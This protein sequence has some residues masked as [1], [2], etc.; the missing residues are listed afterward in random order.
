MT[1][2][3]NTWCTP[4]TSVNLQ[5][6]CATRKRGTDFFFVDPIRHAVESRRAAVPRDP[7]RVVAFFRRRGTLEHVEVVRMDVGDVVVLWRE[8]GERSARRVR[9]G[10]ESPRRGRLNVVDPKVC[11]GRVSPLFEPVRVEE[12]VFEICRDLEP[13]PFELCAVV[14]RDRTGYDVSIS[15]DARSLGSTRTSRTLS[16]ST[17]TRVSFLLTSTRRMDPVSVL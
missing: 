5:E 11:I 13:V 1:S 4:S 14:L 15:V 12:D 17:R 10:S 7:D 2:E 8:R 3:E 16:P 9:R 6:Q